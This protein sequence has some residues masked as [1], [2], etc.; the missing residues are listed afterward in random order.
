MARQG[1]EGLARHLLACCQLYRL[2]PLVPRSMAES[3]CFFTLDLPL[4]SLDWGLQGS[5]QVHY[6]DSR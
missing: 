4:S 6:L 5:I 3:R 2:Q 1:E